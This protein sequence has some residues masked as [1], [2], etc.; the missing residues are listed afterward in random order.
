MRQKAK[1]FQV[2]WIR[3]T[4]ENA[5]QSKARADSMSMETALHSRRVKVRM[6]HLDDDRTLADA[7]RDPLD[8]SGTHVAGRAPPPSSS[9]PLVEPFVASLREPA[10]GITLSR[11]R[12]DR[13]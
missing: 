13:G 10:L 7:G 9:G 4:V 12:A 3:F 11:K 2:K 5:S 8:G 1:H 6:D